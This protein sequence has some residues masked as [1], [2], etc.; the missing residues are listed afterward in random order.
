[1]PRVT[2]AAPSTPATIYEYLA[3]L[4][5]EKRAALEKLR[6]EIRAAA[7]AAE[8]CISYRMPAF[9]LDGKMLVSFAAA[10]KHC[11]FYAGAHPIRAHA[12]ELEGYD[13]A[14]G[15]IRF[16]PQR[17]LPA[18]LVRKLVRTRVAQRESEG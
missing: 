15:T 12:S 14:K 13:T 6:R 10:A 5:A 1:L 17:P 18:A 8:E 2:R 16:Q 7:P 11:S 3:A 4:D 9:R